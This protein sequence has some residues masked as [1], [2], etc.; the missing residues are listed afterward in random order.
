LANRTLQRG[1]QLLEP[2]GGGA[3]R[4]PLQLFPPHLARDENVGSQLQV[5]K[6]SLRINLSST[7][8]KYPTRR[9]ESPNLRAR[10]A[11]PLNPSPAP[12]SGSPRFPSP[13]PSQE[14]KKRMAEEPQPPTVH[15]GASA[16]GDVEDEAAPAA[17]SAEDRKAAAALSS[18]DARGDDD[19]G[20]HVDHE[21]VTRAMDRLSGRAAANGAGGGGTARAKSGGA[22]AGAGTGAG[23]ADKAEV[24]KVK[25]DAE[26]LALV[27]SFCLP[28]CLAWSGAVWPLPASMGLSMVLQQSPLLSG[29][30]L[31]VPSLFS[32]R[33]WTSWSFPRGRRRSC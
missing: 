27:V 14:K 10:P 5:D 11:S 29:E 24:K 4:A 22:G 12:A 23:A 26:D 28:A 6:I 33:R 30:R 21:A 2:A 9:K 19:D 18:L 15:E 13:P 32:A 31:T 17:K 7:E 16:T 8:R 25:I 20:R 3:L 1:L